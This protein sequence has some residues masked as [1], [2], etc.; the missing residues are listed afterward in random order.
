MARCLILNTFG[1]E[2]EQN[3]CAQRIV[4][5][6]YQNITQPENTHAVSKIVGLL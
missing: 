3:T 2:S 4:H 5:K 6:V 1:N